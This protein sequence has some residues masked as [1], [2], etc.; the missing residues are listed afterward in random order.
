MLAEGGVLLVSLE[1][2]H[3]Y[4]G[5]AQSHPACWSIENS[6]HWKRDVP[7]REDDHRY[8]EDNCVQ[9]LATL[10]SLAIIALRLDGF[11]SIT[12]GIAALALDLMGLLELLDWRPVAEKPSLRLLIGPP[13]R[14]LRPA[15]A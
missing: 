12:E 3:C 9:I 15:V 14:A 7:L 2:A 13:P 1:F 8:W 11:W 4:Q 5:P 6:W 10:R